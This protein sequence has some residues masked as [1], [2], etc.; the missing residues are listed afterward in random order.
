MHADYLATLNCRWLYSAL[1]CAAL[2]LGSGTAC[3][4]VLPL[5]AAAD[6]RSS[7]VVL[8]H[9]SVNRLRGI[10][11][12]AGLDEP[13]Y[14]L[15]E[16]GA[17]TFYVTGPPGYVDQVLRLA[18]R[19]DRPPRKVPERAPVFGVVK[20]INVL[21]DDHLQGA[22]ANRV[23]APGMASMIKAGL[24]QAQKDQLADGRLVLMAYP[25]TN[26]LLI[27]GPPGQVKVI[28][29]RVAELDVAQPR[30]ETSPGQAHAVGDEVQLAGSPQLTAA[31]YEH[32]R[33]AFLRAD[34]EFSP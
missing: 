19:M 16:H 34:Q 14:P 1:L 10:M 11:R 21:V 22:G 15:R 18:Q 27:K 31:Q 23:L 2:L 28:E 8:R 13:R 33:R 9:I 26:S 4:A 29:K 6:A 5:Y 32:V 7:A 30:D 24:S 25:D 3:G 20:V 17:G 12:R